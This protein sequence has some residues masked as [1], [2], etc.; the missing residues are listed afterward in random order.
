MSARPDE[1]VLILA[2]EKMDCPTEE[3]LIR[4]KLE[5][6]PGITGLDFNLIQRR[7]TVTHH[8]ADTAAIVK[9]SIRWTWRRRSSV[10]KAKQRGRLSSQSGICAVRP[11]RR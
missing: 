10:A 6:M 4:G 5:S 7:L 8:L 9:R 2:I 3:V 1:K 11:K